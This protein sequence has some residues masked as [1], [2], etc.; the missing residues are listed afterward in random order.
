MKFW[1]KTIKPQTKSN[2]RAQFHLH[3]APKK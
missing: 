2:G 3:G 1:M